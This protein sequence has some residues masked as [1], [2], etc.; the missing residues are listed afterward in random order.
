MYSICYVW[1]EVLG[2]RHQ[3][4]GLVL[5]RRTD[6]PSSKNPWTKAATDPLYSRMLF[7]IFMDVL[8]EIRSTDIPVAAPLCFQL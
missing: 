6:H 7:L 2:T 8:P 3:G 5:V 4:R 1:Y